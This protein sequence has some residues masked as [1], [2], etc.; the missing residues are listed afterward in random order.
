[1]TKVRSR[2]LTVRRGRFAALLFPVAL[3][4]AA[5]GKSYCQTIDDEGE[6][7]GEALGPGTSSD[8]DPGELADDLREIADTAPDEVAEHWATLADVY[9]E[10]D[11]GA[12]PLDAH[13]AWIRAPDGTNRVV[14]ITTHMFDECGYE[15]FDY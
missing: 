2:S 10:I 14:A 11:S 1:M 6:L 9:D 3:L 8:V 5:C 13:S 12:E 15:L 4:T 7:L